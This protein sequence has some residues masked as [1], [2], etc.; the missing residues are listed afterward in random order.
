MRIALVIVAVLLLLSQVVFI[1]PENRYN[2][3]GEKLAEA[4]RE[5][6]A[7]YDRLALAANAYAERRNRAKRFLMA[8]EDPW[9]GL[10]QLH[11][12]V[13]RQSAKFQESVGKLKECAKDFDK[14]IDWIKPQEEM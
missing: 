10:E 2:E 13:R 3:G 4:M 1:N 9:P 8:G 14:S 12:S 5:V 7:N 6:G 11:E